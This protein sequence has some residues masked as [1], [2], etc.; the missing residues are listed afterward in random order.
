M[1]TWLLNRLA[2]V[3]HASW[4]DAKVAAGHRAHEVNGMPYNLKHHWHELHEDH[5]SFDVDVARRLVK[6]MFGIR[7]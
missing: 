2:R 3:L 7:L 6:R 1:T 4:R 5:R